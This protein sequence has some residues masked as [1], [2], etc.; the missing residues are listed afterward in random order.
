M[1]GKVKIRGLILVCI[2]SVLAI[3]FASSPGSAADPYTRP[4]VQDFSGAMNLDTILATAGQGE[5]RQG[6]PLVKFKAGTAPE[7]KSRVHQAVQTSPT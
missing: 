4:E 7:T 6:E 1:Q 5:Y 3:F 2:L